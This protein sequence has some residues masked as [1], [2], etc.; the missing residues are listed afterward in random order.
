MISEWFVMLKCSFLNDLNV[1]KS[2]SVMSIIFARFVFISTIV[3]Y[4]L[5]QYY[6]NTLY[7]LTIYNNIKWTHKT[8][9]T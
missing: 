6:G 3:F 2:E 8:Y 9:F 1:V 5:V 4:L 7:C